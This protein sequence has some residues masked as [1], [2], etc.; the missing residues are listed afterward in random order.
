MKQLFPPL[1]TSIKYFFFF[2]ATG[3]RPSMP[4]KNMYIFLLQPVICDY[5][6]ILSSEDLSHV[7]ICLW[8]W[9]CICIIW[10]TNTQK[11]NC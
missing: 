11:I 4:N 10:V 9:V 6:H 7:F 5:I 2:P 3:Y 8:L 1:R